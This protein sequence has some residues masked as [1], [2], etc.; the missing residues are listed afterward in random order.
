MNQPP[1]NAVVRDVAYWRGMVDTFRPSERPTEP[2]DA[3]FAAAM[4][5]V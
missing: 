2:D 3:E 4:G 5:W 1:R